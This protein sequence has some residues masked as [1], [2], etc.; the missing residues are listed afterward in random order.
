MVFPCARPRA[1]LLIGL[2][3]LC[4]AL[5]GAG[6]PEDDAS[7]GE[8][9]DTLAASV[10][11][12]ELGEGGFVIG[13]HL[14]GAQTEAALTNL[15]EDAYPGT[16]KFAAGEVSVVAD[17][18]SHLVLAIFRHREEVPA[19]DVAQMAGGLM[20]RFGE[21][22]TM[23]HGKLIYWAYGPSGKI[24]GVAYDDAKA[25]GEI[26]ILATVKFSSSIELNSDLDESS[27]EETATIYYIITSDRL[28][29][30]FVNQP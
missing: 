24:G 11:E 17:E 26:D 27:T 14:T 3:I 7:G 6:Q 2:F 20:A 10:R 8:P 1:V 19:A 4:P 22:T 30:Q 9:L 28:L 21:P 5:L 23:A 12:L 29:N 16:I 13:E 18:T 25:T 15:L